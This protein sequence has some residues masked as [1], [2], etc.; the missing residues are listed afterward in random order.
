MFVVNFSETDINELTL[1]CNSNEVNMNLLQFAKEYP[2]EEKCLEKFVAYR[3][4]RGMTCEKCGEHTK[5]YFV[6]AQI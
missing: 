6:K 2:T 3:L 1:Y 4:E 5:H